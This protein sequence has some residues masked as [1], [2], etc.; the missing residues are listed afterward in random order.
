MFYPIKALEAKEIQSKG[1]VKAMVGDG[2]NGTPALAQTDVGVVI[3]TGTDVE[4]AAG[5]IALR[6]GDLKGVT[7]AIH[8]S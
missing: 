7:K 1:Y 6:S 5:S 4:V 8:L 2:I 3:G